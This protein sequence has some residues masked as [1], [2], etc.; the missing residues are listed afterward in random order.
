MEGFISDKA[1]IAGRTR[2]KELIAQIE[3][4]KARFLPAGV[5]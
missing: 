2:A 1:V 4:R 3:A 5:R